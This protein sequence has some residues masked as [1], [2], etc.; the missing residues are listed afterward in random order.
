MG[1]YMTAEFERFLGGQPLK[2]KVTA[3]MLATMA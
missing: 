3:S 2:Y 1:D